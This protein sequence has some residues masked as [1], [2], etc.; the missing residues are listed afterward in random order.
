MNDL[1]HLLFARFLFFLSGRRARRRSPQRF[2]CRT[3]GTNWTF[4]WSW[5]IPTT[6]RGPRRI[7]SRALAN[8]SELQFCLARRQQRR[9]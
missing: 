1:R 2:R 3:S 7:L 4:C 6:G 5:R 8:I 9:E